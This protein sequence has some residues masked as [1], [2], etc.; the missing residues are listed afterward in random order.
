[1]MINKVLF[2]IITTYLL[3]PMVSQASPVN[4]NQSLEEQPLVLQQSTAFSELLLNV[5]HA[6]Q[7]IDISVPHMVSNS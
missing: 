5:F 3:L 1:M 4:T 2:L 7:L 6:R